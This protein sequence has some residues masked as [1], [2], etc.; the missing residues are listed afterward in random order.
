MP[1]PTSE[2]S[3]LPV[4]LYEEEALEAPRRTSPRLLAADGPM[5]PRISPSGLSS[6]ADSDMLPREGPMSEYPLVA[7]E[8]VVEALRP[9][10]PPS[11]VDPQP[12]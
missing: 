6:S 1:A 7:P 4:A 11:V 12:R 2:P 10:E 5:A 3:D 9:V 8:M